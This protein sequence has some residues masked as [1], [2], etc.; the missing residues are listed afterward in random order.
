MN[1]IYDHITQIKNENILLSAN[2]V[3]LLLDHIDDLTYVYSH[4][5]TSLP[6]ARLGETPVQRMEE[7]DFDTGASGSGEPERT[8]AK[9]RSR[10]HRRPPDHFAD[11]A[12]H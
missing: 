8:I 4:N 12:K 9:D 2:L 11:F 5:D 10:R 6:S 7:S 1:K 3:N